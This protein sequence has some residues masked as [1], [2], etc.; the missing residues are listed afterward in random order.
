MKWKNSYDFTKTWVVSYND[1]PGSSSMIL[2]QED[3]KHGMSDRIDVRTCIEP[4]LQPAQIRYWHHPFYLTA[5]YYRRYQQQQKRV[6]SWR[7]CCYQDMSFHF[8]LNK[9]LFWLGQ[10]FSSLIQSHLLHIFRVRLC[11]TI[12]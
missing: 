8:H 10:M 9:V 4:T 2:F 7:T 12:Y 6:F 11:W 1:V 3:H 5:I